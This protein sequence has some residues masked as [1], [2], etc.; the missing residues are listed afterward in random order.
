MEFMAEAIDAVFSI[1]PVFANSIYM[2]VKTVEMRCK[3]PT[4]PIHMAWIYE[5][6]PL[7]RITGYFIP[8]NIRAYQNLDHLIELY[9]YPGILGTYATGNEGIDRMELAH[10]LGAREWRAIEILGRRRLDHPIDP[11]A[12]D[13]RWTASQS[14][15]YLK[16]DLPEMWLSAVR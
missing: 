12:I 6:L 11:R 10:M 14:W 15:R 13:P 16:E 7:Q 5:T 8:G 3:P 4:K 1:K 9:G 2:G